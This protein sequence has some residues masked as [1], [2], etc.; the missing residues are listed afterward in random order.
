MTKR[1]RRRHRPLGSG[2]T[3]LPPSE[4]RY[5][6][7][8]LARPSGAHNDGTHDTRGS[9]LTGVSA[10]GATSAMRRDDSLRWYAEVT[11]VRRGH[12]IELARGPIASHP[13]VN[14]VRPGQRS[15]GHGNDAASG[16]GLGPPP[17]VVDLWSPA[18][19]HTQTGS[20]KPPLTCM[21]TLVGWGRFELPF[22]PPMRFERRSELCTHPETLH[23]PRSRSC[24]VGEI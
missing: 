8:N 15:R 17:D 3:R 11:H 20:G 1:M 2:P 23:S 22:R 9:L 18:S 6:I 14:A 13:Q 16:L 12:R 7:G 4:R 19:D 10:A 21:F 5:R 24:R